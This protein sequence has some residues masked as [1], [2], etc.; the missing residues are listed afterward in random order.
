MLQC[1]SNAVNCTSALIHIRQV[2]QSKYLMGH[3]QIDLLLEH[4]IAQAC[5]KIFMLPEGA[6]I[7]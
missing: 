4:P 7:A 2:V 3:H 5:L 1:R 6:T